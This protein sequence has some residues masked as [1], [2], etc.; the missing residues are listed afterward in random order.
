MTAIFDFC[1]SALALFHPEAGIRVLEK[2]ASEGARLEYASQRQGARLSASG[3]AVR[4]PR[5]DVGSFYV[6]GVKLGMTPAEAKAA[7]ESKGFQFKETGAVETYQDAVDKKARTLRVTPPQVKKTSGPY[8]LV[9]SDDKGNQITVG[10][11]AKRDGV[12]VS[13]INLFMRGSLNRTAEIFQ[14]LTAQYGTASLGNP[15]V[16]MNWCDFN[17]LRPCGMGASRSAPKMQ[18]RQDIGGFSLGL[19]NH[20]VLIDQ[21]DAEI[22]SLFPTDKGERHRRLLGQ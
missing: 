14:D 2:P 20:L 1:I 10:F 21:R 9:G 7:L 8:E 19:S 11:F 6:A 17:E 16:W 18:F 22:A 15:G 12:V 3:A 4:E 13:Y 5:Y